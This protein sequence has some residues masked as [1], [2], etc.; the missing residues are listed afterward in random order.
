[1]ES[2]RRCFLEE[3]KEGKDG[4]GAARESTD[5]SLK[6]K[7]QENRSNHHRGS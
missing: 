6:G 1:M 3:E 2:A 4:S 5:I 7:E